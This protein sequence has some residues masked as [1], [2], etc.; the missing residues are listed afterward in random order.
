MPGVRGQAPAK[1]D[2][3]QESGGKSQT[4]AG[5]SS[6]DAR[7]TPS[8]GPPRLKKTPAA[9]HPLPQGGEGLPFR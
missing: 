1:V 5:Y 6:G 7:A 9:G 2:S 4:T 8:P 3:K